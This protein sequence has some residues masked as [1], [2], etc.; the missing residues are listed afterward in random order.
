MG[1]WNIQYLQKLLYVFVRQND[2]GLL[3]VSLSASGANQSHY[4]LNYR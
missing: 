3:V 1:F 2:S 4:D